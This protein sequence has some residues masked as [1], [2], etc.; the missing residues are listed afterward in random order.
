[1]LF[2]G[3]LKADK[4]FYLP[5]DV[6][7]QR[8]PLEPGPSKGFLLIAE[9]EKGATPFL[10]LSRRPESVSGNRCQCY[11]MQSEKQICCRRFLRNNCFGGNSAALYGFICTALVGR[12]DF[13]DRP[14]LEG[15]LQ[16]QCFFI[17]S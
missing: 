15:R 10:S 1:M 5:P 8:I 3:V 14:A 16:S 13:L 2:L 11:R 12:S 7:E 17:M 6:G 9:L 4:T